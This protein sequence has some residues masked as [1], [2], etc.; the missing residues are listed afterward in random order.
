MAPAS[1]RLNPSPSGGR[2]P[3]G[4]VVVG[5]VT[6]R[7]STAERESQLLSPITEIPAELT[8]KKRRRLGKSVPRVEGI[9]VTRDDKSLARIQGLARSVDK[10][11]RDSFS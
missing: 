10:V 8:D 4:H 11:E 5:Q 2:G 6:N 7:R 3:W 9:H 1:K